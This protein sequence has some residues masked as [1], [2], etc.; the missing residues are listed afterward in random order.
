MNGFWKTWLNIWC[1]GVGL[2]GLVLAGG[3]FAATSGPVERLFDILGGG[4]PEITPALRF[5]LAVMGAVTLG[6]ALTF[7][8]AF[9]AAAALGPQGRSAWRVVTVA[10]AGWYVIDCWLSIATGF[11]LNAVPNTLLLAG[12]PAP[13]WR[14][15][16]LGARSLSPS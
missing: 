4:P 13:V 11:A 14:S 2:F 5:S 9:S 1:L 7:Y 15:G 3:A 10:V 12:Y 16:V 8:A 6:W